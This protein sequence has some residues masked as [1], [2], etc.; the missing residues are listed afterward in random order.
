MQAPVASGKPSRLRASVDA[1]RGRCV[2]A[3]DLAKEQGVPT[4][5]SVCWLQHTGAGPSRALGH[6][7]PA[8]VPEVNFDS[9]TVIAVFRGT[10]YNSAGI[11]DATF[12][13]EGENVR[14]RFRQNSF[15]TVGGPHTATPFGIFVIPRTD[16]PIII[17][18]N[19][20]RQDDPQWKIRATLR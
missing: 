2:W 12:S 1:P 5:C 4:L 10:F 11:R 3:G 20:N 15:Q 6:Y 14:M 13:D 8:G 9:C 17:E 16:K 7:N 18:E 19:A